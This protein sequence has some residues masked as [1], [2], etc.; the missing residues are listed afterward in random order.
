MRPSFGK[1]KELLDA[2]RT[3][4][5]SRLTRGPRRVEDGCPE[6]PPSLARHGAEPQHR[7]SRV[8][9][10]LREDGFLLRQGDLVE[11][12]GD[13]HEAR[14]RPARPWREEKLGHLRIVVLEAAPR[15]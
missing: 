12:R 13:E 9:F 5:R 3:R 14:W 11:L 15:I 4:K 7:A 8:L 1:P 6:A 2:A 10:Q